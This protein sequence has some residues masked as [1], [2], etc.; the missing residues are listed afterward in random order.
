MKYFIHSLLLSVLFAPAL[1][2]AQQDPM[3]SQYIFNGH[4]INPAFAG[5]HSYSNVT[6]VARKQWVGFDGSP[7]TSYLSFDMPFEDKNLGIGATLIND[8]IGVTERTEVSGSCAYHLQV[9]KDAKLAFGLRGGI[10]YYRAKVS[11]LEVWDQNDQVFANTISGKVL[12]VAGAG[13]YF[14][15][16]R[17]YAGISIPNVISYTP[18]TMLQVGMNNAP[19]LER[20]YFATVGY[21]YT[22]TKNLDIKPSLLVKYVRNAPVQVDYNLNFFLYKTLWAGV[23]YRSGDGMV[24]LVAYQATKNLRVGYAYD[25]PFTKL[26]KYNSGSHEIMIAWDFGKAEPERTFF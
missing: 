4:Y 6:L 15:T 8:R 26:R 3:T 9:G 14:Y 17:F 21:A 23:S 24:G 18:G 11:K 12:P 25:M 7:L 19:N 2:V 13:V 10:T 16:E 22:A 20:H 5:S 1:L